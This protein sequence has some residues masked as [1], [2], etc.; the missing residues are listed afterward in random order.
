MA[1][2]IQIYEDVRRVIEGSHLDNKALSYRPV[3]EVMAS[4]DTADPADYPV[5]TA[6][7]VLTG[8][9]MD[10][11][12]A[13]LSLSIVD[14]LPLRS[15]YPSAADFYAAS[16]EQ[17]MLHQ[18]ALLQLCDWL[19]GL[20]KVAVQYGRALFSYQQDGVSLFERLAD[21]PDKPLPDGQK[22]HLVH[23]R[24]VLPLKAP[25]QGGGKSIFDP[26]PL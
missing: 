20:R 22:A 25:R 5:V 19:T 12:R 14:V 6:H 16:A 10:E 9:T 8:A 26:Q 23:H 11:V 1:L 3:T 2:T 18:Y 13:D 15:A 17:D 4:A 21:D 7:L 24:C